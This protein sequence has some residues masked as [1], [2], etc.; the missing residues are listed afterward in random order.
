MEQKQLIA[1]IPEKLHQQFLLQCQLDGY[2]MSEKIRELIR[3]FLKER[4]DAIH[5]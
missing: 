5:S 2:H 4:D 3:E 1:R